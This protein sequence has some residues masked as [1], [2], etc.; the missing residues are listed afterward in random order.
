MG[1]SKGSAKEKVMNVY[2]KKEKE[3]KKT[4]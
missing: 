1:N 4:T 3:L 2:I